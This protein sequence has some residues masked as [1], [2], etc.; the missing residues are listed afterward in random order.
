[1]ALAPDQLTAVIRTGRRMQ[2]D[3][4]LTLPLEGGDGDWRAALAGFDVLLRQAA[5]AAKA[6][7]LSLALS[8]RWCQLAMLPWSDALLDDTGA[9][10][11]MQAQFAAIFG[12]AA[13]GWTIVCDDAPYGEPRLACAVERDFLDGLHGTALQHGHV[14]ASV[15]SVLAIA[16]RALAPARPQAFALAEPG[17]LVLAAAVKGR[18]VALQAQP[19]HGAWQ[20]ELPRAWQRWSLRAPE[21]A[22][23]SH[24]TLVNL[25]AGAPAAE[26]PARFRPT[27]L[28]SPLA[29]VYAA[30]ALMGR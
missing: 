17:R 3:S 18:I 8:S 6:L 24:V 5:P 28:P 26:L 11:F 22:D 15:E 1:V 20:D 27:A 19:C 30:V 29:P 7:P 2:A 12:E 25:D 13:R 9:R 10:R 23:V 14:I 16:W 21:L 4:A